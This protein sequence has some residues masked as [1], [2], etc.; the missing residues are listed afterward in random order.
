MQDR[1]IWVLYGFLATACADDSSAGYMHDMIQC[2][3]VDAQAVLT[4][5]FAV[6][7]YASTHQAHSVLG[8][9]F[10]TTCQYMTVIQCVGDMR[11]N[12]RPD[13]GLSCKLTQ[14]AFELTS[15]LFTLI[16][17]YTNLEVAYQIVRHCWSW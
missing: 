5:S 12:I 3:G 8:L 17:T 2:Y 14:R 1:V 11:K 7:G 9:L 4:S 16:G 6:T 13:V 10:L 15:L